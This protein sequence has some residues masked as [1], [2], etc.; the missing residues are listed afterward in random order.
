MKVC[1]RNTVSVGGK[2]GWRKDSQK[3]CW[4]S[5]HPTKYNYHISSSDYND[6]LENLTTGYLVGY[7]GRECSWDEESLDL[8]ILVEGLTVKIQRSG[9][10]QGRNFLNEALFM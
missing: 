6:V 4:E 7:L 9:F 2:K 5:F 10:L 1:R 8:T 3:A